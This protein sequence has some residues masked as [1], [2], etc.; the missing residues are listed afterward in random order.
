[1]QRTTKKTFQLFFT[2][3]VEKLQASLRLFS[4]GA[5]LIQRMLRSPDFSYFHSL[6][7]CSRIKSV[8][9]WVEGIFQHTQFTLA[10]ENALPAGSVAKGT[11]I[12]C[13]DLDVCC[14]FSLQHQ[15]LHSLQQLYGLTLSEMFNDLISVNS[16]RITQL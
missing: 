11:D 9:S 10:F 1:M 14:L 3:Q 4:S 7:T 2:I 12:E 5:P 13:S 15:E 8:L 16:H 6:P